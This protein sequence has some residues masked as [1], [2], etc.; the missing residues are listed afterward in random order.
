MQNNNNRSGKLEN[1][2]LLTK[3][4]IFTNIMESITL[5]AGWTFYKHEIGHVRRT[6]E[7]RRVIRY[8]RIDTTM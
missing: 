3:K 5:Y 1:R 4:I 7:D 8:H 6:A 2:A